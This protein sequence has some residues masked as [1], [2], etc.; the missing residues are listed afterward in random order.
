M[1]DTIPTNSETRGRGNPARHP[2][3][4]IPMLYRLSLRLR[5]LTADRIEAIEIR[6]ALRADTRRAC[7]R[8]YR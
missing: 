5:L 1:P 4:G 7:R 2:R 8:A 6:R 3:K